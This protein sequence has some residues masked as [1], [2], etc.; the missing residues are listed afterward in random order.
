MSEK[1]I[2]LTEM[3]A[4]YGPANSAE[5]EK[6]AA[7]IAGEIESKK[8]KIIVLDDDPTGVQTVHG[9]SVYTGWDASSIEAGFDEPGVLFFILTNS[10]SMGSAETAK[11]H[12]EIG[13]TIAKIA[14]KKGREFILISRSDSTLRGHYPL[15]TQTLKDAI[16]A[17]CHSDNPNF[18]FDGEIICPFFIEGG[19]YTAGNI[20]YVKTG[21]VL[22][23]AAQTE[24]AGDKTFGYHHSDLTEW[25][26][27]MTGSDFSPGVFPAAKVTAVS[28]EDIRQTGA[29]K[30]T[31]LLMGVKDFGKVVVNALDYSDIRI[32]CAALYQALDNGKH[33]IIRSAAAIPKVL[34][35]IGEKPLLN[36]NDLLDT[37]NKRGGLVV[38]GSHVKKTTRQLEL[39]LENKNISAIEFNTHLVLDD[40]KF[41]EEI[42]RVQ[43]LCNDSIEAGRTTAVFTCRN[44]FDLNTGKKEDELRVAVKIANAVTSFVTNLPGRPR[45]IISKGGITSSEI[46]TKALKV[47]KALV[48]GQVLPG[49]PVWLTGAESRF[50]K[51]PYIIFPGNVGEEDS[52]KKIVEMLL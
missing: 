27:E 12:S 41:N 51:T 33:F 37:G 23:P 50:P 18:C 4:R 16:E 7:F 20:H 49:I 9:V 8:R 3:L 29:E 42:N 32:F 35:N 38:I 47:K 5:A 39:L 46:G 1:D 45:F 15:E 21:D 25:V 22:V 28:I 17:E 26:E 34:G 40:E 24:F 44:R 52:L 19:R 48:L 14:K 36:K 2:P 43:K 6:A 31:A 30:V 11:V 13:Q 10:R